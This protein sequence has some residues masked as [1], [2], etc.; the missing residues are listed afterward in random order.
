M[1]VDMFEV[2]LRLDNWRRWLLSDSATLGFAL[3]A[4]WRGMPSGDG[5]ESRMPTILPDAE[6]THRHVSNLPNELQQA[7]VQAYL[8]T[9]RA[10]DRARALGC[11]RATYYRRLDQAK[12]LLRRMMSRRRSSLQA[13]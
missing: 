4:F 6:E 2:N 9:G 10:K 12:T 1:I 8:G 11:H 13:A 5:W 7:I 3:S